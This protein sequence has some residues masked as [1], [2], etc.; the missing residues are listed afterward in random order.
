LVFCKI[1]LYSIIRGFANLNNGEGLFDIKFFSKL[2]S[3]STIFFVISHFRHPFDFNKG[4]FFIDFSNGFELTNSLYNSNRPQQC[5][6]QN[7]NLNL[8]KILHTA[9]T[10]PLN[11]NNT[12]R[13]CKST[14]REFEISET[15]KKSYS[16]YYELLV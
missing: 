1:S 8:N 11:I 9:H 2:L 13:L 10:I 14:S 12:D 15:S 16:L 6:R 3:L 5:T 7:M 4:V